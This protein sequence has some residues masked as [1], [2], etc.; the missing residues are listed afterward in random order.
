[1][2]KIILDELR[3][4]KIV[5]V[6][7][8]ELHSEN[9]ESFWNAFEEFD[10]VDHGVEIETNDSQIFSFTWGGEFYNYGISLSDESLSKK[11]KNFSKFEVTKNSRWSQFIGNN[12]K[13]VKIVWSKVEIDSQNEIEYPQSMV[14]VFDLENII[15]LSASQYAEEE[16]KMIPMSDNVVIVFSSEIAK[17][18]HVA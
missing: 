14:I 12:I 1:M 8:Y 16:N 13:D 10:T 18:H 5:R 3:S 4:L 7:Y 17:K 9:G 15:Y 2:F 6:F 11:L